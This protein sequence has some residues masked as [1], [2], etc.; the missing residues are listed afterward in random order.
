MS[1]VG[2][3]RKWVCSRLKIFLDSDLDARAG[4]FGGREHNEH[5]V[6][7]QELQPLLPYFSVS[8]IPSSNAWNNCFRLLNVSPISRFVSSFH[9]LVPAAFAVCNASPIYPESRKF[10]CML[11]KGTCARVSVRSFL[12]RMGEVGISTH[13]SLRLTDN[14]PPQ[15]LNLL[16][17][18]PPIIAAWRLRPT[19]TGSLELGL[20]S[21]FC[22]QAPAMM[23]FNICPMSCYYPHCSD[24][25]AEALR[26]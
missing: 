3:K 14:E 9:A 8:I 7:R 5:T 4:P 17:P 16:F 12:G 1:A 26:G 25:N 2:K 22:S 11:S 13:P 10:L 18:P 21:R 6:V 20:H 23:P 24:R 15:N 19:W